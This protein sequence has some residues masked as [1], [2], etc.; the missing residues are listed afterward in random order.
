MAIFGEQ[1]WATPVVGGLLAV[2]LA[3][4]GAMIRPR[5]L[6]AQGPRM[7]LLCVLAFLVQFAGVLLILGLGLADWSCISVVEGAELPEDLQGLGVGQ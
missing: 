2:A 3:G 7:L 4:I 6:L 1:E 5:T